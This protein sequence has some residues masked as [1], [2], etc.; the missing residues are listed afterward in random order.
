MS[1]IPQIFEE[2]EQ[3]RQISNCVNFRRHLTNA[4]SAIEVCADADMANV[5]R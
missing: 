1:I 4:K 3:S 5:A 2:W